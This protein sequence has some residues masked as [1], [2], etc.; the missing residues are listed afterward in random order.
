MRWLVPMKL[1]SRVKSLKLYDGG[2][3]GS[4]GTGRP[5]PGSLHTVTRRGRIEETRPTGSYQLIRCHALRRRPSH[6][7]ERD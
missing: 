6:R 1:P 4:P 2:A 7:R 5:W 3:F